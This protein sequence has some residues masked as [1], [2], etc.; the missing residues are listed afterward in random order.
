MMD[1]SQEYFELIRIYEDY[2]RQVLELKTWSVTTGIAALLTT[3]AA[4]VSTKQKK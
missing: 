2:N 1:F 4:P 3:L